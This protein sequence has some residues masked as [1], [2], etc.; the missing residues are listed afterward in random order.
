[1]HKQQIRLNFV[2]RF[3]HVN[4]NIMTYVKLAPLLCRINL[5]PIRTFC[6]F[7]AR[8]CESIFKICELIVCEIYLKNRKGGQLHVAPPSSPRIP[9]FIPND[10]PLFARIC[11]PIFK[12]CEC[13]VYPQIPF[14]HR[15][16]SPPM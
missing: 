3:I 7:L 5:K 10:A 4:I 16:V 2:N 13:I 11:E 1:M 15:E 9:N 14:F 6:E 8:I 12:I